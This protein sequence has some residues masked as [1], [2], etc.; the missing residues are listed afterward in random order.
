[1]IKLIDQHDN[2]IITIKIKMPNTYYMF[3]PPLN[4]CRWRSYNI[5]TDIQWKQQFL[6]SS[7]CFHIEATVTQTQLE[8]NKIYLKSIYSY[9]LLKS[10]TQA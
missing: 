10:T 7:E 6:I 9:L 3:V 4:K 2:Y 5:Q 1:M 8:K